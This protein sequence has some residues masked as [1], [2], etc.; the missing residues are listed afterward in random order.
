MKRSA[1]VL[2][3]VL[4]GALAL[5]PVVLGAEPAQAFS[6]RGQHWPNQAGQPIPYTINPH[7]TKDVMD[8]S[9]LTAIRT[10]FMTWQ[11]IACTFITFTE[12][13]WADPNMIAND[14]KNEV[15]WIEDSWTE[16]PGTIALTY[17]FFNP[18]TLVIT[19]ADITIN[20]VNWT[21]TTDMTQAG[22][23]TPAKVDV[24]SAVLHEIGHF[25]GLDHSSDPTA[26][27]YAVENKPLFRVPQLD[28]VEGIC[29][30][31][32]NGMPVPGMGGMMTNGGPVGAPCQ[33]STDCASSL[34]VMDAM[35]GHTYCSQMCTLNMMGTCPAGYTC[36]NTPQ[37]NLCLA[38][39]IVDELCD[40][41][42]SGS[43]CASGFCVNVPNVNMDMGFCSQPC[44]PTP[45]QPAQCPM[46]YSCT[47]VQS[48]TGGACSPNTGVCQPTGKGGQDQ[49]CYANGTCKPGY[50]CVEY[51]P[52]SGLNYCYFA[53]SSQFEG[54]SCTQGGGTRCTP[55]A[56][57]MNKDVCFTIASAGQPCIPAV[58]DPI[59][60]CAY[61]EKMGVG[62]ALCYRMCP[63]GQGDCQAQ[64]QC[65]GFQG[66][67]NLCVPLQGFKYEGETCTSDAECRSMTCRTYGTNRLCTSP[68]ATTDPNG[69]G[70][71]FVCLPQNNSSQGLCWPQSFSDPN[72][73]MN[74]GQGGMG[75]FCSC[76]STNSCDSGC[77][78]DPDCKKGCGCTIEKTRAPDDVAMPVLFGL[79]CLAFVG[80][81]RRS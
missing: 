76:D 18:Q 36:T 53:C 29:S 74:G 50:A 68:C 35:D 59:S 75:G 32:P 3:K 10:A 43:Q 62:S 27:M 21:Y 25:F 65:Q 44:D 12:V 15:F 67:P 40:F 61:D 31:Y 46:G 54:Q 48:G 19:D 63:N 66:L 73:V 39:A 55:V 60:F 42:D 56:S 57:Q 1:A 11:S 51:Y 69:C 13:A 58:C 41:C 52:N 9:A 79:A 16:Q 33:Q 78:C 26:V 71:G 28:D 17:V 38:P 23:G 80:R 34:C 72:N 2:R 77:A 24:Q 30:L 8:G 4:V 49:V 70:H 64:E 14:Q 22:T 45:G 7:G 81:R 5:A 37:G 6:T 20:G 47:V